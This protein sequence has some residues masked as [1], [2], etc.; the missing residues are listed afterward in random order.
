MVIANSSIIRTSLVAQKDYTEHS[1][2]IS[3]QLGLFRACCCCLP[4][5][6]LIKI[7][8]W[9]IV[10]TNAS[11]LEG[12]YTRLSLRPK[13][14][15]FRWPGKI[16]EQRVAGATYGGY[17]MQHP[18]LQLTQVEENGKCSRSCTW[19]LTAPSPKTVKQW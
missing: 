16:E 1:R 13:A 15:F 4:K 10:G 7:S 2:A 17:R 6:S 3:G 9:F 18:S 5:K 14:F 19:I 11:Y 8:A 12:N